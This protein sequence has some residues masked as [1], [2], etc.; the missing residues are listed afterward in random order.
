MTELDIAGPSEA[1]EYLEEIAH[2]M[3]TLFPIA[4]DEANGRINRFFSGHQFVTAVEVSVLLH[5]EP[6][7]WAK[8]VYYGENADW[9][10]GED[11]LEPLPYP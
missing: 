7:A 10:L 9:W 1:I 11:G 6:E 2:A 4:I 3:I 8:S 5:E